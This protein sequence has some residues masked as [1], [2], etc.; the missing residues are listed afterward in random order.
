MIELSK[1][2]RTRKKLVDAT[3]V[4][5]SRQ[6]FRSIGL[7]DTVA[8]SGRP[9]GSLYIYFPDGKDELA[10]ADLDAAGAEWRARSAAGRGAP[11]RR[12]SSTSSC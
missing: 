12:I 6:C 11:R 2:E 9:P 8:E 5:L 7:S 3:G 4:L 1:G 10:C